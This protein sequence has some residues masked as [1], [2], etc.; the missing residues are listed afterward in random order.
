[1]ADP[2]S[3]L[4]SR[5]PGRRVQVG[6]ILVDATVRE[7]HERSSNITDHPIEN[8]G[9]ITDHVY[10][11]PRI[12]TVEGEVT[13]SPVMFFSI[14]G[15]VSNRSIEAFDQLNAL[16]ETRDIVTLVTGLKS[17]SDM[18]IESLRF[19]KDQ[20]T[21][22]RLQFTAQFKQVKKAASQ[23]IGVAEE[24]ASEEVKDKVGATKDIGRQETTEATEAQ[25]KKAEEVKE[26]IAPSL[27]S[28]LLDGLLGGD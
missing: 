5:I 9:F 1:M 17:Y 10:E 15:G 23:I 11:N 14:L 2:L 12:V 22:G 3:I 24:V 19:P 28:D 16:Y 4:F 8:G 26:Q 25:Q 27:A 13:D 18:V 6:T 20:R 7:V 21:G